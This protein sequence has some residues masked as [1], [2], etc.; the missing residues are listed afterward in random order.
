MKRAITK[1]VIAIALLAG[2][3]GVSSVPLSAGAVSGNNNS[4]RNSSWMNSNQSNNQTNR[5]SNNTNQVRHISDW[6][7]RNTAQRLFPSRHIVRDDDRWDNNG[8]HEHRIRFDD[9]HC[10]D[11]RD[12]G[13][14]VAVFVTVAN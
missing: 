1:P 6:E 3:M 9:N 13:V 7:A 11:V 12:D 14:V 5:W 10:V 4:W 8:R 2:V